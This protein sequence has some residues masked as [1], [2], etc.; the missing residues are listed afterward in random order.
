MS[1]RID[2]SKNEISD[3]LKESLKLKDEAII[4]VLTWRFIQR[5]GD[6]RNIFDHAK[7]VGPTRS[8]VE[9]LIDGTSRVL[10]T[11]S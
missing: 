4:D 8:Q 7:G 11:I 5:L 10:K 3:L 2:S 9:E 1:I 6:F